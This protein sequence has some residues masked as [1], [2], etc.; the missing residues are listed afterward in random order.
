MGRAQLASVKLM[1]IPGRLLVSVVTPWT[2]QERS[3]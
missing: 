1:H 3:L 2:P